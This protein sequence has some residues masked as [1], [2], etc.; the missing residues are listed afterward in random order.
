[1]SIDC[2]LRER[3][4]YTFEHYAASQLAKILDHSFRIIC[5]SDGILQDYLLHLQKTP[6]NWT[7][8]FT[9]LFFQEKPFCDIVRVPHFFWVEDSLSSAVHYLQSKFATIGLSDRAYCKRLAK[10]NLCFLPH[11]V[12]LS[13]VNE[14]YEQRPFDAVLFADL[15]DTDC[16]V[17]SWQTL[18]SKKVVTLLKR[19]VE[20]CSKN[21]HWLP[22]EGVIEGLKEIEIPPD[23][24]SLND[25]LYGVETY[26]K[27]NRIYELISSIEGVRLDV[28]GEHVG[29]NWLRRLKNSEWIYLHAELPYTEHFEVLKLSKV[30]LF[31][32][33]DSS[34][35]LEKWFLA[36]L[37]TGCLPITNETS[38]LKE[39]LGDNELLFY[40]SKDWKAMMQKIRLFLD[41][42]KQRRALIDQLQEELLPNHSWEKRAGELLTY[43]NV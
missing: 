43:L 7:M 34:D 19:S 2:L 14:R 22:I 29:N 38:Y 12:D 35:H 26:L 13:L 6:P 5:L 33:L 21:R 25:L 36:A 15:V 24:V 37:A 32:A 40:P 8:A 39:L 10:P 42:P 20:L 27:A 9:D 16:T 17:E 11:G 23:E 31:D 28:F 30:V 18:F 3:K 41:R 1:M 4:G